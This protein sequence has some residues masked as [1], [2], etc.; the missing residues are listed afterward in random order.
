MQKQMIESAINNF[1]DEKR[2]QAENLRRNWALGKMDIGQ[3][4]HWILY[5]SEME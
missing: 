2:W 3:L 5:A 4:W 1:H